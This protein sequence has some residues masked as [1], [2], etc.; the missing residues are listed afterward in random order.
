VE[1][2]HPLEETESVV[3]TEVVVVEGTEEDVVEAVRIEEQEVT[4]GV[5]VAEEVLVTE[6]EEVETEVVEEEEVAE[7]E[8]QVVLAQNPKLPSTLWNLTGLKEFLLLEEPTRICLQLIILPPGS[9]FM[10]K[11]ELRL[12]LMER[13]RNIDSGI[14]SGPS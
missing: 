6:E 8:E 1:V 3:V 14:P 13:R 7:V 12:K 11:R 4:E 10:E 9:L 2:A 5:E